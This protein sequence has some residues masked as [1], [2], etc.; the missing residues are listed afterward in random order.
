MSRVV[1]PRA[2][3]DKILSSKPVKRLE[4]FG[5]ILG[6]KLALRSRGTAMSIS[7]K[8]PFSFFLLAPRHRPH[9]PLRLDQSDSALLA[10]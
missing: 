6:S 3:M 2:Y 8:S 5:T 9:L 7:P 1:I 10:A 4:P